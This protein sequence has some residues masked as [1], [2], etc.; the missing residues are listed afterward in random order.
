MHWLTV[1]Q[2]QRRGSP[3]AGLDNGACDAGN[4]A[5]CVGRD[6]AAVGALTGTFATLG[7]GGLAAGLWELESLPDAIFQG[8]GA[9][10]AIFGLSSSVF[11]ITM[12]AA[13]AE[14][15]CRS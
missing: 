9:F 5:A 13:G 7:S 12:T 11:D 4:I 2:Q 10:S 3:R 8:L 15:P 6:L 14:T 1:Q